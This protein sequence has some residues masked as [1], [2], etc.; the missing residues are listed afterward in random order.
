[1]GASSTRKTPALPASDAALGWVGREPGSPQPHGWVLVGGV[2]VGCSI[3]SPLHRN[4]GVHRARS[5]GPGTGGTAL[6]P[7]AALP[8]PGEQWV[9]VPRREGVGVLMDTP[10]FQLLG[11]VCVR[12]GTTW[13]PRA[14]GTG[15]GSRGMSCPRRKLRGSMGTVPGMGTEPLRE[16]TPKGWQPGDGVGGHTE[17]RDSHGTLP[18]PSHA[19]PVCVPIPVPVPIPPASLCRPCGEGE[20][21]AVLREP[22]CHRHA[23]EK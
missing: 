4:T 21:S 12:G 22:G 15:W 3:T 9:P 18:Q 23:D 1:M 8:K 13:P 16:Q 19:N 14:G 11:C 6:G 10:L 5:K 20:C 2:A 7:A 17:G